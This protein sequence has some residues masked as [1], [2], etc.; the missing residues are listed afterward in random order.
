M[1]IL[2]LP[3]YDVFSHKETEFELL[4]NIKLRDLPTV[5]PKCGTVNARVNR[6]GTKKQT[7]NDLPIRAKRVG[8]RIT[9]Q[10]YECQECSDWFLEELP[11]MNEQHRMTQRLYEYIQQQSLVKTFTSLAREVGV[12]EKLVRVI[13]GEHVKKLKAKT[14]LV[15]PKWMGIDEVYL[16]G[17]YRCVITNVKERTV[18]DLLKSRTK[19]SVINWLQRQPGKEQIEYVTMDMW[20]PYRDAVRLM[21][22]QAVI[23]VDKFHVLDEVNDCLEEARK[24]IHSQLTD[25]QRRTLKHDKYTLLARKH[26]LQPDKLIIL[27]SWIKNF[28][29]L[30]RAYEL[31]EQFYDIY[32]LAADSKQ[33]KK[34]YTDWKA[35][36]PKELLDY[37][38]PLITSVT[39]WENE[40]FGYFDANRKVTNAYTEALNGLIKITNREGRGYSFEVV[41]SKIL[42]NGD[43]HK[44]KRESFRASWE[45]ELP[46]S[47]TEPLAA[48]T[49]F[50]VVADFRPPK[51]PRFRVFI[52]DYG[53][54]MSQIPRC[55]NSA[56]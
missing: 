45:D 2:S 37:F 44:V 6:N 26:R 38:Q 19:K 1:D 36:V 33:A 27:E 22:P 3:R 46:A 29:T 54:K 49:I 11:D 55:I 10:K 56:L 21:L 42:Y 4:I 40:I 52:S 7:Y 51:L 53:V 28:P 32:D 41:R 18:I 34:L 50:E 5:C 20:S 43:L 14:K 30:G 39:N 25:K 31:K 13:F 48:D 35:G 24:G 17:D 23:I 9:R 47:P 15:T 12:D 16:L 8:L